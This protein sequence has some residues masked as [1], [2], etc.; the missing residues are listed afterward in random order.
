MENDNRN[1]NCNT[2]NSMMLYNT[3]MN[4]ASDD[5]QPVALNNNW[6]MNENMCSCQDDHDMRK[7][8]NATQ[9]KMLFFCN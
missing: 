8:R 3:L 4:N 7:T 2:N 9:N 6:E 5:T 1:C